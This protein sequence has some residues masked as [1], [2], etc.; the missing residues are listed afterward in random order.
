MATAIVETH[1]T[2]PQGSMQLIQKYEWVETQ[3]ARTEKRVVL[4]LTEREAK[5][6]HALCGSVGG[7]EDTTL[8]GVTSGTYRE[9]HRAMPMPFIRFLFVGTV[10]AR[11]N[12]VCP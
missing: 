10:Q 11:A 1:N 4:T 3:P 6:L 7:H 9:L 8:R 5:V 12:E 2:L